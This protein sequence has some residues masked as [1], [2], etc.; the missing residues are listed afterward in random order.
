MGPVQAITTCLRK[1]F[2]FSGRASRSEFWWLFLAA[3]AAFVVA[4]KLDILF[5]GRGLIARIQVGDTTQYGVH[6]S[7]PFSIALFLL[8]FLPVLAASV[9]RMH[10]RGR[11][12]WW[13]AVP[14]L[15]FAGCILYAWLAF[16][17]RT[18][19]ATGT[20]HLSGPAAIP[21]LVLLFSGYAIMIWNF[22]SLLRRSQP[23]P[24]PYGPNPLE[25]TP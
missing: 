7:G 3:F 14:Y 19:D 23:G 6:G 20:L 13:L 21:G 11:A 22:I 25:V 17:G 10:D 9:R 16:R 18:A 15:L 2:R 4:V 8:S 1:S 24:N 12:G 5:F